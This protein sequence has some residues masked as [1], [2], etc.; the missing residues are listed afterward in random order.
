MVAGINREA[1][2]KDSSAFVYTTGYESDDIDEFHVYAAADGKE[3]HLADETAFD[4]FLEKHPLV[5]DDDPPG[6][7]ADLKATADLVEKH[8]YKKGQSIRCRVLRGKS[9]VATASA[10][11]AFDGTPDIESRFSPDGRHVAWIVGE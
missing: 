11:V 6:A 10:T 8:R 3:L 7:G 4:A 9:E 1:W 5:A 2:T